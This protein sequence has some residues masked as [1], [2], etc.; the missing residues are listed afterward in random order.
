MG[1]GIVSLSTSQKKEQSGP[2]FISG[3]ADNGLS[4]DTTSGHI[5]LGNDVADPAAPAALL[6]S[7]E[8]ITEDA[9]LNLFS[10]ILNSIQT[11][12]ATTLDGQSITIAGG[13]GNTPALTISS[14]AAGSSTVNNITGAG[15]T[16]NIINFA[17]AGGFA[18]DITQVGGEV[19]AI[20]AGT[21]GHIFLGA[22]NFNIPINFFSV[23]TATINCQIGPTLQA[24]NGASLQVSGTL[25]NRL[26]GQSQGAGTYNVNR[27]LDS[28]KLFRNSA[29]V[30]L[31]LPNMSGALSRPGFIL[32]VMIFNISGITITAFGGQTIRFGSLA[33]TSGG[34]LTSTDVGAYVSIINIDSATWVTETFNGVWSLT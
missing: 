20:Q 16:A 6:S 5:V 15:G 24:D 19:F 34:T 23:N 12:I 17:G 1:L 22:S 31:Q 25:T 28:G 2:P 21:V 29:A 26:L 3:S 33:T 10:L 7:R 4:V 30:N 8:I 27:D 14:G 32:R 18:T 11:G 13:I 9:L